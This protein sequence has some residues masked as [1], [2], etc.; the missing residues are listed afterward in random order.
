M[1]YDGLGGGYFFVIEE[2]LGVFF[3]NFFWLLE[4]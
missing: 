4:K 1:S 3:I 2:Y